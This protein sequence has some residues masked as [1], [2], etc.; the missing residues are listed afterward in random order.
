M[1]AGV[2]RRRPWA[3]GV[4]GV[5]LVAS[6]LLLVQTSYETRRLFSNLE[7]ERALTQQLDIEFRRLDAE[8]RTQATG[9]RVETLARQRLAMRP[10]DPSVMHRVVDAASA[11]EGDL[12]REAGTAPA[13]GSVTR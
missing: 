9:T 7:R 11:V 1:K 13:A 12:A 4:L 6:G 10:A 8:R 3:A 5:A 2:N